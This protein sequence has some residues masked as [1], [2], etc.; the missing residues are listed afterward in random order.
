MEGKLAGNRSPFYSSQDTETHSA[1]IRYS[2]PSASA[3]GGERGRSERNKKG[4]KKQ[5]CSSTPLY[6]FSLNVFFSSSRFSLVNCILSG[7]VGRDPV[8]ARF[9]YTNQPLPPPYTNHKIRSWHLCL[10]KKC[11]R[12][13]LG[14]QIGTMLA[15]TYAALICFRVFLLRWL[16]SWGCTRDEILVWTKKPVP[17][18]FYENWKNRLVFSIKFNF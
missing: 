9:H 10:R 13:H 7:A 16:I 4:E 15:H 14:P 6:V 2:P 18:G 11:G 12:S 3:A 17:T 8:Q 1:P 5:T